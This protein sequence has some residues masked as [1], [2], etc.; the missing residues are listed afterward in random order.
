[1]Q[2]E[3]GERA[4]HGAGV[5]VAEAEPH[6]E[7]ARDRALAGPGGPV[8]RDDH[9]FCLGQKSRENTQSCLAEFRSS[10]LSNSK[11]P[12]K[13]TPTQLGVL[14]L[15]AVLRVEGGDRA[16]HRDPV[17]APA[18]DPAA[19]GPGR[20]AADPE[21]VLGREDVLAEGAQGVDRR[22]DAVG[23]LRP[24]LLGSAQAAV[25]VRTRGGEREQRQLVDRERHL[26]AEHRRRDELGRAHLEVAGPL[27]ADPAP[28]VDGDARRPS[29]RESS[30]ARCGAG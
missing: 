7:G 10:C 25:A 22:L 26:R 29:A 15:D 1:M 20:D 28:V 9:D 11:K 5:E 4:V 21:A 17:V 27:A 12:G 8:D 24:Q 30:A 18:L 3:P 2:G 13:L 14:D 19:A 16:E 6:R 23:L